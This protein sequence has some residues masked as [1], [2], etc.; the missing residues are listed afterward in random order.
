MALFNNDEICVIEHFSGVGHDEQTYYKSWFGC[1]PEFL[2]MKEPMRLY[3]FTK[4]VKTYV[5]WPHEFNLTINTVKIERGITGGIVFTAEEKRLNKV[6]EKL[7]IPKEILHPSYENKLIYKTRTGKV[8]A[9]G[10]FE[11]TEDLLEHIY[12][13]LMRKVSPGYFEFM[14]ALESAPLEEF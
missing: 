4:L 13:E 14:D 6:I 5:K 9:G 2:P 3:E 1:S 10:E 11:K 12:N 8:K 7:N